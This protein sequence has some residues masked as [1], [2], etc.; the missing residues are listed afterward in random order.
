MRFFMLLLAGLVTVSSANA[1][2]INGVVKE[3]TP[4]GELILE[5]DQVLKLWGLVSTDVSAANEIVSGKRVDCLVF[6]EVGDI[7]LVDCNLSPNSEFPRWTEA[8]NLFVWLPALG[9]A[10]AEC[11]E[12]PRARKGPWLVGKRSWA[13]R[14]PRDNGTPHR[15]VFVAG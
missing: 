6:E 7:L 5:D 13:S 15:M 1:K 14:I 4:Q 8:M 9:T 10:K 2:E 12:G 3:I 11:T